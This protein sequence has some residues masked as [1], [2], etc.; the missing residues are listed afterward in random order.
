MRIGFVVRQMGLLLLLL[1]AAMLPA[2]AW[3]AYDYYYYRV[4]MPGTGAAFLALL[5]SALIGVAAGVP[6]LIIGQTQSKQIGRKEAL[7]LVA[8]AWGVGAALAALPY[9]LWAG[10]HP[11]PPGSEQA[12]TS[13]VNCYFEAMSGLTTTGASI[14]TDV[15]SIPR[16]LLFWRAFTH[17]IGGLG[18]VV[19]FVAVLPILGVGGKR[20]F[21]FEAPGPK[22][23]G[24]RPRIRAAAQV[25]WLLYLGI[26]LAEIIA[27]R[28]AGLGWFNSITHAFATLATGGFSTQ[29]ASIAAFGSWKVDSIIIVF[30]F[31][32]GVN[33]ALYDALL[34]GRWREA[35]R[36]PEL[37]AYI[38][39]MVLATVLIAVSAMGNPVVLT[40]GTQAEGFWPTLRHCLF[41]VVSIQTT[42]G[43][44]TADFDRWSFPAQTILVLLMFIGGCAG[45]T[46]GGIKVIR[47]II[48]FKVLYAELEAVFR[49][50]VVRTPRVGN[51]IIDP[52]MRSATL[53]YFVLIGAVVLVAT[54]LFIYLETPQKLDSEGWDAA[55]TAFS[56]VAANLNNI[57]PGL[58]RVG[59]T[60]N[61]F[62]LNPSTKILL[63]LLMAL[64]RLELYAFLVLA[65]PAFWREE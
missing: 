42:T 23:E 55:S 39:V 16:S 14:L 8:L 30:M 56:A 34:A 25:L 2:A 32:A 47:C 3:S 58:D 43:F 24:V 45:S 60:L 48:L 10:M 63:S 9:R 4:Q 29:N 26:T 54:G 15:E 36:N 40:D 17:W 21:R 41:T 65:L 52:Q 44:C 1:S 57:G 27:L 62:W 35:W 6:L 51:A 33:F 13:F 61:Y 64:G 31:M 49:P 37:R 38:G 59:A 28:L 46:G 18:I 53:V 12:F 11:L 5:L 22:K 50:H 7:L 20:L 19:L